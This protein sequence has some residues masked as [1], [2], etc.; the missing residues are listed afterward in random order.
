MK[1]ISLLMALG[2]ALSMAG[3]AKEEAKKPIDDKKAPMGSGLNPEERLDE[4]RLAQATDGLRFQ[5][6]LVTVAAPKASDQRTGETLR[7]KAEQVTAERNTWFV[8]VGAFRDA[9]IADPGNAKSYEGLARA[10]L[11]EGKTDRAEAA[12][13]TAVKLSP[14]FAKARYELGMV[15]QMDSD[16][17]GAVAEWQSLTQ[18]D[19]GYSDVFARMAIASYYAQDY[20]SAWKY[21]AQA[22]QRKQSVPP[23]FR[24]LLREADPRP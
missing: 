23:Q 21:L 13:G 1:S 3:C 18:I 2:V 10:L 7:Q 4:E 16:Y 24:P 11:L 9:I 20:T 22:D 5:G 6:G 12:L 15:K 19:P 17:V 14:K 8:S